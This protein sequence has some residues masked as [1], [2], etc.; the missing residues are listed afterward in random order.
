MAEVHFAPG[1]VDP[2]DKKTIERMR[3]Q[4]RLIEA[5]N[6]P[7]E[8]LIS[9]DDLSDRETLFGRPCRPISAAVVAMLE[10]VGSPLVYPDKGEPTQA[11]IMT[12]LYLLC[13]DVESEDLAAQ[14]ARGELKLK[15]LAW[16]LSVPLAEYRAM[17]EEIGA[18]F[19][20][21]MDQQVIYTGADPED[22]DAKKKATPGIG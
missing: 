2:T 22:P 6:A 8:T 1:T 5:E 16:G 11:D 7:P 10:M 9:A 4:A 19:R 14:A 21:V 12:A 3:E 20:A 15:A 17:C 18:K 13:A